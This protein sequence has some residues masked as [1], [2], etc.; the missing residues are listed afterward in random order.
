MPRRYTLTGQLHTSLSEGRALSVGLKLTGRWIAD[1][2][3]RYGA[4]RRDASQQQLLAGAVVPVQRRF[5]PSYQL[6]MSYQ[7]STAS[8][9]GLAL[10]REVETVTCLTT[11]P[12]FPGR[13]SSR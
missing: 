11:I 10:G 8:S 12:R 4:N 6:Q 5:P 9:F 13:A 7:H 2:G 3:L 1:S